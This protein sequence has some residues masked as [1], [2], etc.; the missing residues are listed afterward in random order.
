M[1]Y[2]GH[3]VID[4][5]CHIFEGWDLDRTFKDNMD[6]QY[7]E[8]YAEFS[9]AVKGSSIGLLLWPRQPARPMG[10]LDSFAGP[11]AVGGNGYA[12]HGSPNTQRGM[13][14]D[15]ACNWDPEVRLR[16]MDRAGIDIGVIFCSYGDGLC[17]LQD[18]GFESA[19]HR[20]YHRYMHGYCAESDGR[21][22]WLANSNLRDIPETVAQLEYWADHDPYFAGMFVPRACPDGSPLDS[23]ILHPLFAATQALDL[24]I[25]IHGG[26]NRPPLTPWL[27]ATNAVYH[28]VGAMYA[29]HGLVGGGA[30]DLFPRLRVGLFEAGC[31]WMPWMIEALDGGLRPGSPM[32]PN[33]KRKPSEVLAAGQ[34]FCAVEADEE[35]IEHAIESLGEDVWLFSTDYPHSGTPWPDG[36][37]MIT[38]RTELAESAKIKLLGENGKRFLPRLT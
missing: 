31:G 24:P 1:S 33:L 4:T 6:P 18:V 5:D 14:I 35:Y 37:S 2:N 32:T 27:D 36:V 3:L 8:K 16:D 26:A 11:R 13:E 28:G 25:W 12:A 19:L 10:L 15:P 9:Q 30:F 21:L 23:P 17:R 7:R 22:R 34:L 20:A 38:E 29:L